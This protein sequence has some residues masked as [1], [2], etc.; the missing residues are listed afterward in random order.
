M[1][2]RCVALIPCTRG[3]AKYLGMSSSRRG[4]SALLWL[5]VAAAA[6]IA[7][8]VG[9]IVTGSSNST[10]SSAL[11][12]NPNLDPGTSMFRPAP[13]FSL[14]DQFGRRVSLT[15]FRGKV[16]ILAFNDSECT[17]VCPL[18]TTAMVDAKGFLGAAGSRVEL[19]G[20]DA[21]PHA[22]AVSDV[23]AYSRVHGMLYQW[24]FLTAPLPRLRRV[25]KNYGID[26]EIEAGQIDHTPALY[27]IDP[28]GRLRRVYL[29]QMN[30]STVPQLGQLLAREASSL[31]PGR[32]VVDSHL[33][34]AA[35][36][37]IG[38]ATRTVVPRAGGGTVRLGPGSSP[39]LLLFFDT[40]DDEVFGDLG[41]QLAALDRFAGDQAAQTGARRVQFTAVDEASVEPSAGALPR[42]LSALPHA[43]SYP[44][45]IDQSGRLADGYEVQDEPWFVLVT[46][47]GRI[48]WSWDVSTQ[49]WLSAAALEQRVRA[50]LAHGPATAAPSVASI[51]SELAGSPGPLAALH[52]QASELLG[53][54]SALA[55]GVRALRG[56]PVVINAWASWCTPCQEEFPLFATASVRWGHQVAFLGADTDDVASDA[57]SFLAKHPV[58]Y[59][60][61]Q[62][63]D[64]QLAPF[65]QLEGLPTTI[66]V[67]RAGKVVY[68]HTGQY[69]A[70]GTL[71]QDI[72]HYALG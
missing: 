13:D 63:S 56:Y 65:A 61:Y 26:V 33:S 6:A 55:A 50:A 32:P 69:D 39:R 41:A 53:S 42:F 8:S 49:G 16:V 28:Q 54:G 10:A 52:D 21:N 51:R 31:L 3:I 9:A 64:G 48:A 57:Q 72:E 47:S 67:N 25:W 4:R 1:L 27:V 23:R 34:Y 19:L 14:T 5:A 18:T 46:A 37:A 12:S 20:I 2:G 44:V 60:S 35:V 7:L 24:R 30:Y 45:A 59:P 62:V 70:A 58:S 15:S 38:P 36:P 66:Y 71:E 17:T 22:T 40:W 11:E 43:P 29:T 68:V